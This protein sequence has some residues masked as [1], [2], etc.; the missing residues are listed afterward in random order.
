M[1]L[2][3][4]HRSISTLRLLKYLSTV[5]TSYEQTPWKFMLVWSCHLVPLIRASSTHVS[6]NPYPWKIKSGFNNTQIHAH[7]CTFFISVDLV[8]RYSYHGCL[9]DLNLSDCYNWQYLQDY[10]MWL[11]LH[12]YICF[13]LRKWCD[14]SLKQLLICFKI[15]LNIPWWTKNWFQVYK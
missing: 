15:T 10:L 5:F 12:F 7:I 11:N 2:F 13:K 14:A 9:I 4:S 1:R 8:L 6:P 3:T